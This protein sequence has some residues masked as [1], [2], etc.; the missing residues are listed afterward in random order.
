[1][2]AAGYLRR[3]GGWERA[4]REDQVLPVIHPTRAI[5]GWVA[6]LNLRSQ[7]DVPLL[8]FGSSAG[9]RQSNDGNFLHT[10]PRSRHCSQ[11]GAVAHLSSFERT[12]RNAVSESLATPLADEPG[13]LVPGRLLCGPG[14]GRFAFSVGNQHIVARDLSQIPRRVSSEPKR[15]TIPRSPLEM[16]VCRP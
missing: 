3:R 16:E 1:M 12:T 9:C 11:S 4:F 10:I 13:G 2:V 14:R 15:T 5:P 6:F 8:R 7:R